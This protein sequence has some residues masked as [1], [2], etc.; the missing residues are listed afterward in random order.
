M[1]PQTAAITSRVLVTGGFL[2]DLVDDGKVACLCDICH[3]N[4]EIADGVVPSE[5]LLATA[6]AASL[7]LLAPS[8]ACAAVAMCVPFVKQTKSVDVVGPVWVTV[9]AKKILL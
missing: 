2:G 9:A 1:E 8:L 4:D 5:L 3:V 6:T 7:I